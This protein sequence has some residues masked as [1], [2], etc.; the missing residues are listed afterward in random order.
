MARLARI[1]EEKR[2]KDKID[3]LTIE[4]QVNNMKMRKS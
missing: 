3:K 2:F 1:R 4:M